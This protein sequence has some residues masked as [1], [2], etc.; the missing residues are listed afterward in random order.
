MRRCCSSPPPWGPNFPSAV[1]SSATLLSAFPRFLSPPLFCSLR[2]PCR[3]V[4]SSAVR[5]PPATYSRCR[6]PNGYVGARRCALRGDYIS[7]SISIYLPCLSPLAFLLVPKETKPF[8]SSA[9]KR[10]GVFHSE[11]GASP[12]CL[13]AAGRFGRG[14]PPLPQA[15]NAAG[16]PRPLASSAASVQHL[17]LCALNFSKCTL[18]IYKS[19]A[20]G[21]VK[22]RQ[23]IFT[24]PY[25]L[26]SCSV[27]PPFLLRTIEICTF[28]DVELGAV[29]YLPTPTCKTLLKRKY[30]DFKS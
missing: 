3:A 20:A 30:E 6:L 17:T 29:G 2:R 12:G 10:A 4:P 13:C 26:R 19:L 15:A 21:S 22:I 5:M 23:K 14:G 24:L 8:P 11:F 7:I 25:P 9:R 16:S 1:P 27:L 18:K 28:A